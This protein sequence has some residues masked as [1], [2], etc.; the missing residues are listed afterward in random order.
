MNL[1]LDQKRKEVIALCRRAGARRLDAF[2]AVVRAD[3]DPLRSD[4]DFL[5]AFDNTAPAVFAQ[6][7]FELKE[8]LE[9]LFGRPVDL[10]TESSLANPYFRQRVISESQTVYAS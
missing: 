6:A 1:F 7:Y 10:V 9:S 3:F 8:G 2:G 4:L 5:V